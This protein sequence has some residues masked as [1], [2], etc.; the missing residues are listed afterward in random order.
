MEIDAELQRTH[1][2]YV[3]YKPRRLDG[4][5]H[6][7]GN[8][9]FLVFD[10]PDGS[11]MAVWTQSSFEG[12]PDQRI[13]FARSRDEGRTWSAPRVIAGPE[14]GATGNMASWGFPLVSKR[15]RIYVLYNRHIGINDIWGHTTGRMAGISSDDLGQTWSP[16]AFIP[17]PRSI[18][19]NPDP[20]F[21]SNWIVWQK[22]LRLSEGKYL[23]GFTRWLSPAVR[24]PEPLPI[25][26]AA[27]SVVEFMRF[28]NLDDHPAPTDLQINYF[29][30]DKAALQV[31]L[32]GHPDVSVVQEPS[33]VPLPDGRLFCVMRTTVGH[34]CWSE[35]ADHGRTWSAPRPLLTNDESPALPHPCS[36]CPIYLLADG[37]YLLLIHNHDGYFGTWGPFDCSD[38]R[39]PIFAVLGEF[40]PKARQP[41]WF[42]APRL[43]MDNA[44]VRIGYGAGRADLAMY[45][46]FTIRNG[47]QVLW[48]PERKFFLLGKIIRDDFV[49]NLDRPY[50]P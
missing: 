35:S 9:H 17:M 5:S 50:Q 26:W 18:W 38:H 47:R 25:W 31:G 14:P 36:P 39:R 45:A 24:P 20:K 30:S 23:A 46:S 42:G 21:P 37:R 7:G 12:Q 44:G 6:E 34:P 40:R 1:P 32:I 8:E 43:L 29:M 19:D 4:S 2:D 16:E 49:Q 33:L 27:A 48:Y 10:G 22:P 15:G 3:V 28:E 41:V 11:L 13:A